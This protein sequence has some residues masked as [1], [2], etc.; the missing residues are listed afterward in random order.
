MSNTTTIP[1]TT[2]SGIPTPM[3]TFAAVERPESAGGDAVGKPE[4]AED[5]VVGDGLV[6]RKVEGTVALGVDCGTSV[7]FTAST[8]KPLLSKVN[9]ISPLASFN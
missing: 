4:L 2:I 1:S 8:R 7:A 5:D 3:L 9:P 6:V